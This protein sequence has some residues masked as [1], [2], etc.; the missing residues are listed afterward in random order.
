VNVITACGAFAIPNA[1]Q[2]F[3]SSF[4]V[5]WQHFALKGHLLMEKLL[6]VRHFRARKAAPRM[7]VRR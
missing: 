7:T 4:G 2:V 1:G 3:L 6:M 5:I